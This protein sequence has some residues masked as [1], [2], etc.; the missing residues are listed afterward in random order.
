MFIDPEDPIVAY[1]AACTYAQ[2][3]EVDKAF[4]A[5]EK[6]AGNSGSEMESWIE[7]D[8]DF[9]SI[10]SDPRFNVFMT[11]VRAARTAA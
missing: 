5:L 8:S 10:R 6:W 2:L 7:S 3:R 4:A 11:K 1:N 9:D